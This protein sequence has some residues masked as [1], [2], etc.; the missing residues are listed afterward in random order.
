MHAEKLDVPCEIAEKS[1]QP[2]GV[3][4]GAKPA[5]NG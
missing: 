4:H 2:S 1:S 5:A 3:K